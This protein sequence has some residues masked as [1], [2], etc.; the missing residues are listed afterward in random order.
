MLRKSWRGSKGRIRRQIKR[1]EIQNTLE[2]LEL[3]SVKVLEREREGGRYERQEASRGREQV[4]RE[5]GD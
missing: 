3:V 1:K 5:A 2:H 4:N